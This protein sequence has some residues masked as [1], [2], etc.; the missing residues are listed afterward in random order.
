MYGRCLLICSLVVNIAAIPAPGFAEA[1]KFETLEQDV[2]QALQQWEVP[3]IAAAAVKDGEVVLTRG[4]GVRKQGDP[5]PVDDRTLFAIASNTKQMTATLLATFVDERQIRWDD[6]AQNH[7]PDLQLA[8]PYASRELTIRDLLCHRNGLPDYGGDIMWWGATND[9]TEVLRRVR[10]VQPISSFRSKWAYQNTMFTAAGEV[11]AKLSGESW[12]ATIQQRLFRPIGMNST[13]TSTHQLAGQSNVATP[14]MRV[15]GKVQIIDWRNLD[16][17]G[18]AASVIS[19][20]HDMGLWIRWLLNETKVEG[21]PIVS[22]KSLQELW[23]PQM[24]MSVS[25]RDRS[26]YG[27][28]FRAYGLGWLIR[29]YHGLLVLCHGGW[30]DG[31]FSFSVIVPERKAGAVVLTNLHNRDL[32][33]PIAYRVLDECLGRV[34]KDWI[35]EYWKIVQEREQKQAEDLQQRE[36]ERHKD[37]KTSL[38]LT[39]FAGTYS[40]DLYGPIEVKMENDQLRLRLSASP[41]MVAELKHWHHDTFQAIWRDPVAEMTFVQ[42]SLNEKGQVSEVKFPMSDFIDPSTYSYKRVGH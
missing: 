38:P 2:R 7:L 34:P 24:V 9:R 11:A 12:D 31:M 33:V 21:K 8:D 35:G 14:H 5:T 18:P 6:R 22:P 13:L 40:N 28:H 1:P 3:G 25:E 20:A 32:S 15:A 10:F 37:T 41:T 36:G 23:A 30:A 26:L 27:T 17:G 39:E 19:N 16:N 4:F 29:D 42:F